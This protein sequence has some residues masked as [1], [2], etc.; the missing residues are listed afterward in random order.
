MSE[1]YSG[2]YKVR[3]DYKDQ[4]NEG[5]DH[6]YQDAKDRDY[7][8]YG[9][10]PEDD[11]FSFNASRDAPVYKD[12]GAGD[13][14]VK[15][16]TDYPGQIRLTFTSAEVGNGNPND[17]NTMPPNQDGGLAVRFQLEDGKDGLTGPVS[18]FDD[19]GIEFIAKHGVTFD[20]RDL[21]SGVQRGDNFDVV[22][23]GT[24]DGDI[25]DESGSNDSYYINAGMGNDSLTG[26]KAN[27]FLVGGAGND[28]M[29][30]MKGTDS[31]LGGGGNDTFVFS[32]KLDAT[33]NRDV[34]VDFNVADDVIWLNNDVFTG[35][36]VGA[37]DAEAF[38]VAAAAAE[39]DDRIIYDQAT[40]VLSFDAN[41]GAR[42]DAVAFAI[43][44]NR[45]MDLS[46]ADFFV[47]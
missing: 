30:G 29:D 40:G 19:E 6:N 12:F 44:T 23:L 4:Y 36:P 32:S 3:A 41:G 47:I 33:A 27:D 20:V 31:L 7:K 38:A 10:N 8:D 37:L 39:A 16:S 13:D 45:P 26:G 43:L 2:N 22:R 34:I 15:V 42:G 9:R 25:I 28:T 35:L 24:K 46:A 18:R 14:Q 21:V 1:K 17:S 5:K 11:R